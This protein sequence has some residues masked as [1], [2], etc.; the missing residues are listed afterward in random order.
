MSLIQAHFTATDGAAF[1]PKTAMSVL[2]FPIVQVYPQ[3]IGMAV[4][5]SVAVKGDA[6]K[7]RRTFEK[8]LGHPMACSSSDDMKGCELKIAEKKV[9]SLM[10]PDN[11]KADTTLIGCYYFYEK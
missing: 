3:S 4:G 5:F 9:A 2:G 6:D 7:I 10:T 11:G 8:Q 1:T